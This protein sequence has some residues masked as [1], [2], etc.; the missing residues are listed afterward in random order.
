MKE[1][2]IQD[3]N[4]V[5]TCTT[6]RLTCTIIEAT[7]CDQENQGERQFLFS[8]KHVTTLAA[9][10]Y[11]LSEIHVYVCGLVVNMKMANGLLVIKILTSLAYVYLG[12]H[13][14]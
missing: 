10:I 12:G 13:S 5:C 11:S 14:S 6:G 9:L 1:C 4:P 2:G 3:H 7:K 8:A